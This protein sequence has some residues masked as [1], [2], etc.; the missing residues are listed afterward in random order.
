MKEIIAK[1]TGNKIIINP[2]SFKD[3]QRLKQVILNE[4][5]KSPTGV[6][7]IGKDKTLFEK[8]IDFTGV[9]DFIKDTII[10]IETSEEFN[11]AIFACLQYCTY[12]KVYKIDEALFDNEAVPEARDDYYE[13]LVACIEENLRP[14]IK[15]LISTWKTLIETDKISQMFAIM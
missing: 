8:D 13:I 1:N 9:I 14:F 5:K 2:A 15:S 3:V 12:K 11:D 7:L 10:G 6:K 4:F